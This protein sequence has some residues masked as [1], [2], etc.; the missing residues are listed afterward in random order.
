LSDICQNSFIIKGKSE[1]NGRGMET[2]RR[3]KSSYNGISGKER[4]KIKV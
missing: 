2:G 1:G 4:K 3:N